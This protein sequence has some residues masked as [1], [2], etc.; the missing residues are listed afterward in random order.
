MAELAEPLTPRILD[1]SVSHESVGGFSC[2]SKKNS[3]EESVNTWAERVHRAGLLS[4]QTVVALEDAEN[5]L[6][7]L[8][9]VKPGLIHPMLH[10]K[11][12]VDVPYIHML[13]TDY[14]YHGKRLVDGPSPGDALLA[15]TLKRIR[16][17][18]GGG[19][20]PYVWALVNPKNKP[21][22]ALFTRHGFA[23][24]A[25]VGKGDAIRLRSPRPL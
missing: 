23:L 11:P 15:A 13:G 2:G 12:L 9:S 20:M 22:Q 16:E 8:A 18:W 4:P 5:K 19:E 24:L 3:W 21:S 7:G 25:P 6:I 17:E 14:R 10:R 1:Q